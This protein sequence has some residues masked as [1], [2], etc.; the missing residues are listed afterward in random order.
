VKTKQKTEQY[1]DLGE[2][3][4][5][6][7]LSS[8]EPSFAEK[9]HYPTLYFSGKNELKALPQSGEATIYYK[10]VMERTEKITRDGKTETRYVVELE[11]HGIE[12]EEADEMEDE[13][14]SDEDAIEEGLEEASNET[15]TEKED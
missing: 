3:L 1:I 15:E 2:T 14:T 10:K 8:I 12:P 9:V 5:P 4:K 6:I 13:A 11:I 7:E